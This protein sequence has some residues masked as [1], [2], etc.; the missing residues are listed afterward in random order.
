[1][2]PYESNAGRLL[3]GRQRPAR[4]C[5]NLMGTSIADTIIFKSCATIAARG[6]RYLLRGP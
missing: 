1:M 2:D 6:Q 3:L 5:R 4:V